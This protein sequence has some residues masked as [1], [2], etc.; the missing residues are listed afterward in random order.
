MPTGIPAIG[1]RGKT[2]PRLPL[3]VSRVWTTLHRHAT[4]QILYCC[5]QR[6]LFSAL[7]SFPKRYSY[8]AAFVFLRPSGE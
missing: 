8:P 1:L 5:P 3:R 4:S 6:I 7:S 2:R